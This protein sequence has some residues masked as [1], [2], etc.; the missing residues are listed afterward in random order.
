MGYDK[1]GINWKVWGNNS[2][3]NQKKEN[4]LLNVGKGWSTT[5]KKT[6]DEETGEVTKKEEITAKIK[7]AQFLPDDS[8]DFN[9]PCKVS[10]EIES[11]SGKSSPVTIALYGKYNGQEYNLQHEITA[12]CKDNKAQAELKLFYVDPYYQ[13]AVVNK[14]ENAS[15]DYIARCSM[16]G[17]KS[18][19]SAPL[20]LPRISKS[21][22]ILFF[23]D[24]DGK[25]IANVKVTTNGGDVFTSD[26]S[27]KVEIPSVDG[28]SEVTVSKIELP[29]STEPCNA[30]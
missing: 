29:V 5:G 17:A 3:S 12:N 1:Y 14:K 23:V 10:V 20:T 24:D 8:T 13:D 28:N 26:N 27:G 9:K 25:N 15:V 18:T 4:P 7:N 19:D 21:N 11:S 2:S 6:Q 22:V 16:K 30:T